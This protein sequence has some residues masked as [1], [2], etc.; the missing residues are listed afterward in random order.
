MFQNV[1]PAHLTQPSCTGQEQLS[2]VGWT[3]W[4]KDFGNIIPQ[5]GGRTWTTVEKG[6]RG[7]EPT[8]RVRQNPN[9]QKNLNMGNSTSNF[10][11]LT[12]NLLL[13]LADEPDRNTGQFLFLEANQV[14]GLAAWVAQRSAPSLNRTNQLVAA[15]APVAA[16]QKHLLVPMAG[17]SCCLQQVSLRN[18]DPRNTKSLMQYARNPGRAFLEKL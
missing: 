12:W 7:S 6:R 1:L 5:G 10:R 13:G 11:F 8:F 14:N 9:T 4:C 17:G 16:K 15:A 18:V 2:V 3:W